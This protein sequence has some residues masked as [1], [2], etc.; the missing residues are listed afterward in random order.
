M[1]L[2][3]KTIAIYA[4]LFA[5]CSSTSAQ[6]PKRIFRIGYLTTSDSAGELP[7]SEA[8]RLALRDL[9]YVEGQ[10]IHVEYRYAG[11]KRDRYPELA[12]EL[13]RLKVDVIVLAGGDAVI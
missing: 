10:N 9:G 11:G 3:S 1:T 12:R 4:I 7:R 13:V 5:F 6:Q 8:I 2:V